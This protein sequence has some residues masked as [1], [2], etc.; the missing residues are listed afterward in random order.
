[1]RATGALFMP[2][3][4]GANWVG[5]S[6]LVA[7][8]VVTDPFWSLYEIHDVSL[9]QSITPERFQGRMFANFRLLN[10]GF[11]VVGTA[12]GGVFGSLIG[13]RETLFIAV[14]LMFVSA[15]VLAVSPV[16]RVKRP[17]EGVA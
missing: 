14:G 3:C 2:L 17:E 7:N 10:F 13:F 12:I 15:T 11:A 8:Q 9:R 4:M 1:M 16:L 5:V 6:F